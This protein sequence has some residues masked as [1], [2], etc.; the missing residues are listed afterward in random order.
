VLGT[1]DAVAHALP[2]NADMLGNLGQGKVF[3][4]IEV[5]QLT[6]FFGQYLAV[7]IEKQAHFK[8]FV[9]HVS[10]LLFRRAGCKG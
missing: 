1:D 7:E 5:E 3:I 4:I 10:T 6:L 9:L 2:R 8:R